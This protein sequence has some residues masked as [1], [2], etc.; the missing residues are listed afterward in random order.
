MNFYRKIISAVLL[1]SMV[2]LPQALWAGRYMAGDFHNHTAFTDGST[3]ID[4][5]T[6]EAV[7]TFGL[8]WYI[9]SG[10]GGGWSRDGRYDDFN[11]DCEAD[12]QG[13]SWEATPG[14]VTFKGDYAGTGY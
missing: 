8:D 11:Y 2:C 13:Y 14:G 10:H 7:G 5:L 3:S 12:G 1:A 6:D 9:Q 4:T